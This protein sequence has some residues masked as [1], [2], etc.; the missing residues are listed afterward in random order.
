[1]PATVPASAMRGKPPRAP[2]PDLAYALKLWRALAKSDF[3]TDANV[4]AKA[5]K[6]LLGVIERFMEEHTPGSLIHELN[7]SGVRPTT[8]DSYPASLAKNVLG[9]LAG[10]AWCLESA[11][12]FITAELLEEPPAE[13]KGGARH[14]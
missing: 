8:D 11:A 13:L 9:D 7:R 12:A 6:E 14:G 10:L 5:A 4:I 2:A 3:M 1:M